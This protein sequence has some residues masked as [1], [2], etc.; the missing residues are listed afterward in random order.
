MQIHRINSVIWLAFL[1][2]TAQAAGP[3][4]ADKA[5]P[6]PVDESSITIA[7]VWRKPPPSGVVHVDG[8]DLGEITATGAGADA[9]AGR[10]EFASD[11]QEGRLQ[12][13]VTGARIHPGPGRTR[14]SV[15]TKLRSF[16][17]FAGDPH[18][19]A[20]VYLPEYGAIVT[21]AAD[22]RSFAELV[23][24]I[25]QPARRT[26][27]EKFDGAAEPTYELAAARGRQLHLPIWLGVGRDC[28]M[29][30]IAT[31]NNTLMSEALKTDS[32]LARFFG[33]GRQSFA[34]MLGKGV[35]AAESMRRWLDEG[36]LPILHASRRQAD[37]VYDL[38]AYVTLES[39]ALNEDNIT[40]THY[41]VADYSVG[42]ST[43]E[44]MTPAQQELA[45]QQ[46]PQE[47]SAEREQTVLYFRARAVN[48][49]SAASY[50]Y[51]LA[52]TPNRALD[53][54]RGWYMD[55]AGRLVVS[56]AKLDGRPLPNEELSILLR[57]GESTTLDCRIPH[58]ALPPE[59]AERLGQQDFDVRLQECRDF[60]RK[61][62]QRGG[63][64][65]VPEKLINDRVKAGLLHLDL[66]CFGREPNEPIAASTGYGPIGSESAPIIQFLDSLGQHQ[67]AERALEYF[68][69]K[70]HVNGFMQNYRGYQGEVGPVLWTVGEHFRY[71]GDKQ[72]AQRVAPKVLRSCEYL[73]S[74]RHEQREVPRTLGRGMI[75]GK[76]AD[77]EDPY[78]SFML[79]GYSYL[80]LKSVA[81][82]LAAIGSV[83]AD[84]IRREAEDFRSDLRV[85]FAAAVVQAPVVPL[86][87]G[88]WAPNPP[89]WPGPGGALILYSIPEQEHYFTHGSPVVRDALLGPMHLVFTGVVEPHEQSAQWMSEVFAEHYTIDNVAPTQ[90][91][92]SRHPWVQLQ[93]GRLNA[94]LQ[95]YYLSLASSSDRET[96][97]FQEH[98]YGGT[99]HKTH[100]EAWFLMQTRWMLWMEQSDTL[101]L[102]A[103]TPRRWL[104]DGKR[105]VLDNVVSHFGPLSV[106]V[107]SRVKQGRIDAEIR[108][109]GQRHPRRVVLNIHHPEG[110]RA[111]SVSSGV[112]DPDHETVTWDN[113]SGDTRVTLNF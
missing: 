96:G 111:V 80:G 91:Y 75:R 24:F 82:M 26:A 90:P 44:A 113:F 72:W 104:A 35:N 66:V 4:Q 58:Q 65:E 108:C 33:E 3:L 100:E 36:S 40:G 48:R 13:T 63:A 50:A 57:P 101:N 107:E 21:S 34:F 8:G 93:Q 15:Q 23:S 106:R 27:L 18:R 10:F 9:S 99:V 55:E 89:P 12:I 70:Q 81:D 49:G 43:R 60:W 83:D 92:Y 109:P 11:C 62:L 2:T 77:A 95:A 14:I 110:A 29:F 17:F 76:M 94:F 68:F 98:A 7:L 19:A 46:M 87:D 41:L 53:A 28:R 67:L 32:L 25:D 84:R 6:T 42:G 85:N 56:I 39:A 61:K 97:T 112:Y 103:G 38:T 30:E 22:D 69:E 47:T 71:T 52:P 86:G 64:I 37:I 73:T 79:N 54:E 45:R 51:F 1:L 20:P 16:S 78:P 88:R 102:L 31:Q 74:R 105:I 5:L 59:R